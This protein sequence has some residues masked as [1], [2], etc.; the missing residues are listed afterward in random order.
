MLI[1]TFPTFLRY[2]EKARRCPLEEQIQLWAQE[3]LSEWPDLLSMQVE[4]YRAQ[5]IDWHQIARQRIFPHLPE[6]IEG[7]S[8]AHDILV[9][10]CER[11]SL[12][13]REIL[14]FES[15]VTFVIYAGLGCGAGWAATFRGAP[16]VLLGLE[17][18][19][20]EDWVDEPTLASLLAH[21]VSHLAYH[22]W[23]KLA[24]KQSDESPW[25]QLIDEGF[26]QYCESSL[27]SAGTFHEDRGEAGW[28]EWCEEH[29]A[30]LA[31]EFLRCMDT[32]EPVRR[33]FGSWFDIEG[34]S[35]TGYYLGQRIIAGLVQRGRSLHEIALLDPAEV[36]RPGLEEIIRRGNS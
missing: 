32:G 4:D 29:A 25:G 27:V 6:R 13:T 26:A 18:I 36:A 34:H 30:W 11:V 12:R 15:S 33:F 14:G 22:G 20:E 24:G 3:Y 17:N 21:E 35:Q 16:A 1:D 31:R 19:V 2:W 8:R 23:R 9:P 28:L 5:G 7:M 10:L